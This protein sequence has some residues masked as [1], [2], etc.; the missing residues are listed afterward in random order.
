MLGKIPAARRSIRRL[1]PCRLRSLPIRPADP[2]QE[3]GVLS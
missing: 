2:E 1:R 3:G